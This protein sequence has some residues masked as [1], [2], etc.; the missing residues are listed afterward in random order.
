[1]PVNFQIAPFEIC[2]KHRD[3]AFYRALRWLLGAEKTHIRPLDF[4][5]ADKALILADRPHLFDRLHRQASPGAIA[6]S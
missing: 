4:S 3:D 1:M 2:R 6:N 5:Q